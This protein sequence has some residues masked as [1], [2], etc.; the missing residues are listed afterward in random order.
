M[1]TVYSPVVDRSFG[2]LAERVDYYRWDSVAA[3]PR[4][5]LVT[6]QGEV[7]AATADGPAILWGGGNPLWSGNSSISQIQ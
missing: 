1:Y 3:L 7:V 4:L 6:A 5:P 2:V